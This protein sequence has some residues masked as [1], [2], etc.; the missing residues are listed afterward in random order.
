MGGQIMAS[1]FE[2]AVDK[3]S[4]VYTLKL[5]GDFDAT[6]A[7]ELIYAIK[8]LPPEAARISIQTNELKN[9]YSFGLDVFR[10][11]MQSLNGQCGRIVF[12]GPNGSR[13]SLGR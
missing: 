9:I 5:V 1:N 10:R 3:N 8:K 2:I 13:F 11:F 7:Y 4:D 12:N 6:S